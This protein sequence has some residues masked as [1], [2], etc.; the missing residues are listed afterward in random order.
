MAQGQSSRDTICIGSSS[1]SLFHSASFS[2]SRKKV[3][4]S[5]DPQR[6]QKMTS[7]PPNVEHCS[8]DI[9]ELKTDFLLHQANCSLMSGKGA[10]LAKSIFTKWEYA[11]IYDEMYQKRKPGTIIVSAPPEN[12]TGPTVV[13]LLGQVKTGKA[14]ETETA[15]QRQRWFL[16]ALK[17]FFKFLRDNHRHH[18]ELLR[19][20]IP[21]GVGCGLAGGHWP[22]YQEMIY[23][24][25]ENCH[26]QLDIH[27]WVK[28]CRIKQEKSG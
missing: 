13:H 27:S 15:E 6:Q 3:L 1:P 14:D 26:N 25:A 7:T 17:S 21:H 12:T 8:A 19:I 9:T 28:I 18:D 10:G 11:S 24:F 2:Q 20:T 5:P 4:S 23:Q 16:E 22:D